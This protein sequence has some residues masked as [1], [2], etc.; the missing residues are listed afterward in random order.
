MA[1]AEGARGNPG[2]SDWNPEPMVVGILL[3]HGAEAELVRPSVVALNVV[4]A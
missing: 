2:K 1:K 4:I 3:Q